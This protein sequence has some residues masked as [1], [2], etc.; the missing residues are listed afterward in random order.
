[1]SNA[2]Y[3]SK[4]EFIAEV[5]S[6]AAYKTKVQA[7]KQELEKVEYLLYE[8]IKNPNDY[9]IV[10]YDSN[11]ETIRAAKIGSSVNKE[12]KDDYREELDD[13]RNELERKIERLNKKISD[14]ETE[15]ASLPEPL[16]TMTK[17]KYIDKLS[18]SAIASKCYMNRETCRRYLNNGLSKRYD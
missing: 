5:S 15:I 3:L 10:G 11:G 18:Y 12:Q 6:L 7:L 1:M 4:I 2:K 9:D 8:K 14:V 13:K 17:L 16:Q